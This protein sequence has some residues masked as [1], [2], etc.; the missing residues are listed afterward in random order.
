MAI[1]LSENEV[2]GL[3]PADDLLRTMAAALTAFS[4]GRVVQPLRAVLKAGSGV[5]ANMPMVAPEAAAM[6]VKMVTVYPSNA[7]KQLPTHQAVVVL[8]DRETGSL[9]A[10]MDGRYI[11][12][13]RTAAVSALSVRYVAGAGARSVALIGS[14]VQAHS[15]Y[16]LLGHLG[17]ITEWRCWS[18]TRARRESFAAEH[19]GVRA[20]ASAEEAVR[21]ASIVV[22]ATSSPSPVISAEWVEPGAH[23]IAVGACQPHEREIDPAL[24][25]QSRLF[26]D[27]RE[28]ALRES[29]DV[30]GGIRDGLFGE[31]HIV[32][33]LGS[34]IAGGV[35]YRRRDGDITLFKSLGL[36]VE[37]VMA[38]ELAYRRAVAAGIGQRLS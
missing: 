16:E 35:R 34:V 33:E 4:T 17:G 5:F 38:A 13:A 15:H 6:G 22:L 12:E 32:A 29:G 8:L 3:L 31:D 25:A 28:A 11:T 37:D 19:A 7:E 27:S 14:G 26:V 10:V 18:P 2:R 23:V 24:V 20:C 21:G 9:L 1:W 36:A 30:V